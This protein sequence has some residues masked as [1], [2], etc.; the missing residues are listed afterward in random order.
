MFSILKD[1]IFMMRANKYV[2][3]FVM[4]PPESVKDMLYHCP[5]FGRKISKVEISYYS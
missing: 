2:C 3:M 1:Y 5:I 4:K